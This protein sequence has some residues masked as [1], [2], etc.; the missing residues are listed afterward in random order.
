MNNYSAT[1]NLGADPEELSLGGR[2]V[3]KLRCADKGPGKRAI[4][5]WLTT[6]VS[7]PD[8][9]TA[10]RLTK[11]DTIFISGTLIQT[12]YK[13]K[14]PRYK[15]EMINSDEIPFGKILQ[16]VKSDTFFNQSVGDFPTDE[17][18]AT[19]DV[20]PPNDNDLPGEVHD[21]MPDALDGL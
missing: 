8:C 19:G 7:G 9:A 15:G 1:V 17:V 10:A 13:P 18:P 11:G 6:L 5:R 4:T 21:N 16:V 20:P 12:E 14:K 3:Y 2:Q